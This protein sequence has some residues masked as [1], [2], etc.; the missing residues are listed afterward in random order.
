MPMFVVSTNVAK[1]DIPVN[2]LS[3]ASSEMAKMIGKPE[4][5]GLKL[6]HNHML[7]LVYCYTESSS[8][9]I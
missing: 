7:S 9:W 1:A 5:V 8:I 2:L 4:Q 3:E 6:G